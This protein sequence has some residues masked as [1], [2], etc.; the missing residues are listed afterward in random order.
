MGIRRVKCQKETF[1]PFL[2]EGKEAKNV[3]NTVMD[4]G[5]ELV[6]PIKKIVY[7]LYLTYTA[8]QIV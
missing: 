4:R 6:V 7:N 8:N 3:R 5:K 1:Y 2:E